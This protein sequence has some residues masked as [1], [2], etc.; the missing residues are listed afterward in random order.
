M[1]TTMTATTVNEFISKTKLQNGVLEIAKHCVS[2]SITNDTEWH[3]RIL[4]VSIYD[5]KLSSAD[6]KESDILSKQKGKVTLLFNV[7]A[8]CGNIPQHSVIQELN[9]MYK[10]EPNFD[11]IAIVVDDFVCHGYP[12]FQNGLM[13][14][15]EQNNL[16]LTP[17][18]VAKKYA[19]DNF[20]TT[21]KF[22]EL[23]NG[24][25]DKHTYDPGYVPGKE[26]IQEQH[27][28]WWYLTGAYKADLQPNGVPYHNE[29]IPWS[30]AE[31]M[32]ESGQLKQP[33]KV[34]AFDPLRGNFE[35][36]LIDKT[37][38]R[39]KR[40]ANGFLL[41]ERNINGETFPWITESWTNDGRRN[42]NPKI[43]PAPENEDAYRTYGDK[44]WPNLLQRK[45]IEVS[46][47]IIS[48]D[49]ETFLGK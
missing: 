47:Q 21:Y 31:E 36:F 32:D 22:S 14:Y 48:R 3:E 30:Y 18:E 8:G 43:D 44:P 11:I 12:E 41:G 9:Q 29:V 28:L 26:K 20:G 17:G 16:N 10:H 24:R 33:K 45:G 49:I 37:G 4:P 38:T 19:E 34:K 25:F 35:K 39:I 2:E 23:T 15:A 46:L 5:V 27:E 7:A 42:H 13:A 40:Y 1:E 6:G